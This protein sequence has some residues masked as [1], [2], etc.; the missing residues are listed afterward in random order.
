[1]LWKSGLFDFG[2]NE[3]PSYRTFS[4]LAAVTAGE[5]QSVTAGATPIVKLAVPRLAYASGPGELIGITYFVYQGTQV[6]A[7]GQPTAPLKADGTV[8]FAANFKPV[9][10]KTYQIQMDANDAHG[11]HAVHTYAL[12]ATGKTAAA[13][14]TKKKR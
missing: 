1:S 8:S 9:A 2:G 13:K 4:A 11:N 5:T 3:K 6:I 12:V 14:S 7:T 10:G